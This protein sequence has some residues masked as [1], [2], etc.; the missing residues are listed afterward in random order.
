MLPKWR[1]LLKSVLPRTPFF[2]VQEFLL[3][4]P[5]T[6]G[7]KCSLIALSITSSDG[8][9][10]PWA[11]STFKTMSLIIEYS[12]N[13]CCGFSPSCSCSIMNC[14]V[15]VQCKAY[16]TMSMSVYPNFLSKKIQKLFLIFPK[17]NINLSLMLNIKIFLE[18]T[19]IFFPV[20]IQNIQATA[21]RN[22]ECKTWKKF[23][24]ITNLFACLH[25]KLVVCSSLINSGYKQTKIVGCSWGIFFTFYFQNYWC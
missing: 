23:P 9:G 18:T 16:R 6:F 17:F 8:L 11:L 24:W 3:K 12:Q 14:W 19:K 1:Q 25:P 7:V 5:N 15:G 13:V 22:F 20:C 2:R 21:G 10:I 4:I